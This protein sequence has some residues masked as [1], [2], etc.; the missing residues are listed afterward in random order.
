MKDRS[1][2]KA[3]IETSESE[4]YLKAIREKYKELALKSPISVEK[5]LEYLKQKG[6][7]RFTLPQSQS[8][9]EK[10]VKVYEIDDFVAEAYKRYFIREGK[11][12]AHEELLDIDVIW[13]KK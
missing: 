13:L 6:K 3:A 9:M 12:L 2:Y 4:E 10:K 8:K 5:L 11:K 1:W 7:M